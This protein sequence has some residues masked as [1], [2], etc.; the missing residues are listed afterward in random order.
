M[1]RGL[2]LLVIV[3]IILM[4][5]ASTVIHFVTDL[6]WF[7][8][9]GYEQIFWKTLTYEAALWVIAFLVYF[10]FI[11]G[12][13]QLAL[14][15][16]RHQTFQIRLPMPIPG[17]LVQAVKLAGLAVAGFFA[18]VA[19]GAA[20]QSW[21]LV[22]KS[23]YAT[24]FGIA[25][26]IFQKDIGFHFFMLPF[27]HALKGWLLGMTVLTSLAVGAV[28][29]FKGV[30]Q[31]VQG[32]RG[33]FTGP[34]RAH[35]SG[36]VAF[37]ALIAAFHF[38]L[39]QYDLL[40]SRGG[41]V[42][43]AG[44]TDVHARLSG[45]QLMMAASVLLA[46]LVAF[47][48]F[49]GRF[50]T[51]VFS[52]VGYMLLLVITLGIYPSLQQKFSVEPNE[53]EKER[54]YILHNLEFTR[55]AYGLDQVE[56][57][58]YDVLNNLDA[59]KLM[60]NK[61]TIENI[62]LW[63]ARPLLSTYKQIQEIRLYYQFSDVDIDRYYIDGNYRQIMISPRELSYS[64]VAVQAQ[65]WVNQRLKYTHGYGVVA[66]PVNVVNSDGMPQ[67]MIKD[68]PPTSVKGLEVNQPAIYYGEKTDHYIFTGA[69][70][71]E[72]DYPVGDNNQVV[73]YS[74]TGG[75][76]IGSFFRRLVYAFEF[77]SLKLII[78]KYLSSDTKVHYHRN[79]RERLRKIAPFLWYD[80]DPYIVVCQGR[81]KW[82]VDAYTLSNRYPY[83]EPLARTDSNYIRNSVKVVIDA[84]DGTVDF[85]RMD[86]TDPLLE[87]YAKAFPG[88]L[89]ESEE[90]PEEI[91]A[92]FRYPIDLFKIQADKY[93]AYHMNDPDVFY[94]REDM[95]RFPSEIY[96]SR[97]RQ[98]EPYYTIMQLDEK[99]EEFLLILPFTPMNKNN[100]I[101][102]M[103]ASSDGENYGKM[104][105]YEFPKKELIYGPMQIEA[106]ID[107]DPKI[108]EVLTLWNQQGSSVIRGN[109]LVIPI[110]DSILYVEP[111]YI[112]AEQSK[113]PELK[114]VI[115][116]FDNMIA[117]R[118]TLGEALMAVFGS[119]DFSGFSMSSSDTN[120]GGMSGA[121]GSVTDLVNSAVN[122]YRRSQDAMRSGDW[123]AY[124]KAQEEL[125]QILQ[126]LDRAV[127]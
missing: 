6:W 112:Q 77:G 51:V 91:R 120:S 56:R 26:P 38:W 93:L 43:G 103:A 123:D 14:Y 34:S 108:S 80:S 90:V 7:Q 50:Q 85:Y 72:F 60:K 121:S 66:S 67:L 25:D 113:M 125:G 61:A 124:G 54:E 11:Y 18:F 63:D 70:T 118:E 75:V 68:I 35:I 88:F 107:Q 86:K 92:H 81:L 127:R 2:I 82:I 9:A 117:M 5:I 28:Y 31:V 94:N 44:Y 116:A 109:L 1:R 4:M 115:V 95:W 71:D 48:V 106:R 73:R 30:I 111:L 23:V 20:S 12:N 110:Y 100:M 33:A 15:L 62:R 74:G 83:A 104:T 65:T 52:G 96:D 29:F 32:W 41:V 22:L 57:E 47:S 19:A 45:V 42:Y 17:S 97:E 99:N 24:D 102:W 87:T 122:A 69:E 58:S 3:F 37:I 10:T 114:R 39:A 64:Q 55:K 53:L 8:S 98:M 27:L 49:R 84:Y 76:D 40:Y 13:F 21:E 59:K 16:T 119:H 105:V 36:M 79:I 89:K 46:G 78:S 126:R 101:A